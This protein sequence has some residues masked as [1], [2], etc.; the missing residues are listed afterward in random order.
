[1]HKKMNHFDAKGKA[2][3]V[4]VS[5][6]QPAK[7]TAVATGKIKLSRQAFDA[8]AEGSASKGDVLGVARVAGIM[9][10]KK[11]SELIPMCHILLVEQASIEFAM[12]EEP[13]SIQAICTVSTSG[14]TGVE[15]EALTGVNVALLAVYDML[16]AIDKEMLLYDICLLEKHGG[17][18]GAYVRAEV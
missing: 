11:T 3:M 9:A 17:K 1:M 18:S 13:C 8:V 15:M 14:K 16:K 5:Q 12:L 7:R 4:D 10:V 6:K 2:V